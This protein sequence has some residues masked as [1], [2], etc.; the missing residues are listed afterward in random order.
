MKEN[1]E[2]LE[3]N[4][5][6]LELLLNEHNEKLNDYFSIWRKVSSKE[7]FNVFKEYVF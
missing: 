4:K 7:Y 2:Q 3:T 6:A 1:I 5:A